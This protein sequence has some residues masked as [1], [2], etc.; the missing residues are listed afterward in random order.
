MITVENL[1][2]SIGDLTILKDISLTINKGEITSIVGPSGAG[3]STLLQI[4]GTLDK[5]SKGNLMING[6]DVNKLSSRK[7]AQFR[8][9]HLG[10]VFQFHHLLP[11]FSALENVMM[12]GLI[13]KRNKTELRKEALRLLS[14]LKLEDRVDHK[15]NEMSGGE[16][17]RVAIARALINKP[18]I[19]LADE[20]SGN[21]DSKN[22]Q[23]LHSLF[24]ELRDE[25]E[26]TFVIITHNDALAQDSNRVITLKDGRI[27]DDK[28]I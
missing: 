19:I 4:M 3:K 26:Q 18:S 8:N 11:E 17:Q 9:E 28:M 23:E 20:P 22:A 25:F 6:I 5:A 10:F 16:Q 12:P 2:K 14:Y 15:P 21:L 1:Y 27:E 7:L 13:G 24:K